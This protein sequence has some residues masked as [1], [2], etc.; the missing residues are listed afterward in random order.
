MSCFFLRVRK[1]PA[2]AAL[3]GALSVLSLSAS[4]QQVSFD[5]DIRP[6]MSD[7]C[8]RCHGPDVS[9]RMANMRLDI[10]EEALKP[11]V[12]GTPIVPG[13]PE[14]SEIIQRIFAKDGHVMPPPFAHKELTES[15]KEII[16]RWVEQ[17][18]KYEMHWSYVPITR[19]PVPLVNGAAKPNPIDAFVQARLAEERL[20]PSSEA[21]RRTLIRRV[22]LDLTGLAPTPEQTAAFVAGNSPDSYEKLVDR[23]LASPGY[24]EKQAV[25]WLDAVR[26]ADSAGFHSDG[27]RPAW[28]YRD[29]VL[30]SF[31]DNKPF[32][33]FTREQLAGDLMPNATVEDKVASAYNRMGRTSAEGGLQPKEYLAKY[34]AERVRALSTNW[35]GTTMGCSECHNHKFDP[36][37]TKDFYSMKAFFADIKEDGLIPDTGS[38]AFAPTMPVYKP[39]QK[40]RIDALQ[41]RIQSA[42][43]DLNRKAD[44]LAQD[45][46][47]WEKDL[48]ARAAAGDLTWT[49]P[50]PISVSATK[51][52][53]SVQ[54][55]AA[56]KDDHSHPLVAT[57]G[58]PGLVIVSGPNPDN[59][60]YSVTVRPGAGMWTSLG[61]EI[62]T[63]P[64]LAG[65]DISRGSDRFVISEVDA[66][67][68]ANGHRPGKRADFVFAYSTVTP[69]KGFPAAAVLDG[70]PNTGFGII[71]STKPP[72]LILRFAQ[73]LRTSAAATLTLQIHQ[74]SGYRQA[75]IGRF[76]IGLSKGTY[77][78]AN[79]P[80]P[81]TD[82]DKTDEQKA[83]K[84]PE[85][86]KNL[87][88]AAKDDAANPPKDN[89]DNDDSSD[90]DSARTAGLPRKLVRAFEKPEAKRSKEQLAL[91]RDYFEYSSPQ[92]FP[93]RLEIAKQEMDL[94]FLEG[95]VAEVMITETAPPRE[96]RILPRGNWMDDSGPVVQ[97]SI[98]EFLGHLNTGNRRA[99]R[100]DL[101]NWLVSPENPLTARVYMNR[102]WSEFFGAGASK[103][104]ED[105]G[106]QGDWPSH[107][108]LLNWL[109]AEFMNPQYDAAATHPWDIRHM[110]R[111][112]V[113]SETYRQSSLSSREL[114]ERDP[115]NRLLARQNRFRVDAESVHD[116][117]L[118]VSGLLVN[119]FGGPSVEPYQP[120]GYLA[121]LNFPKRSWSASHGDDLYRRGIYTFWQRTFL[122][123]TIM[124]FDA[125]T[126]EECAV[127][128]TISNTPL[129]ALDLL[130]DPTFVEAARVFG[131][132]IL[133][134]GGKDLQTQIRWAFREA[135]TRYPDNDE[136]QILL[137]L[138]AKSVAHF[139]AD[140]SQAAAYI[141]TGDS[142]VPQNISR[143]ELA[144]M[145]NVA[146]AILNLHEVIT[147]D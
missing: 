44:S 59:E 2:T 21:D 65:A 141:Q 125:P 109:A 39:G 31:R 35:L 107:L 8:F 14:H 133:Q 99:T 146:R 93:A 132:H 6:I 60:T 53:I 38:D 80:K 34:G 116:L 48:L 23:L 16:R 51:A 118:Q 114:D 43:D 127:F 129:Q 145:S 33:V 97:P 64:S 121:A 15:Q 47:A 3:V 100:L 94:S 79:N 28:P 87:A 136:L 45:R 85:V 75:T 55:E 66:T 102:L 57:T 106:S 88:S 134:H 82:A 4:G 113:L 78:W 139:K 30:A 9:S 74:D 37:L 18:A 72:L 117:M 12:H 27:T 131:A 91:V 19:P 142:A 96:T 130:N 143:V 1:V 101:A 40:E 137:D 36:V 124:N 126:R 10:R 54:T 98:P 108:Q 90:A 69:A 105:L 104:V 123:P 42:K 58:G 89:E 111:I 61:I 41:Q 147:R 32:D 52:K 122:H 49:F 11:K 56:E 68:S 26:Y 110:V 67:Y 25:R 77:S 13:D 120:D 20:K 115:E 17:G 144:A 140:G 50:I 84:P 95:A 71:G 112:I 62:D 92:L 24:A 76:R 22:T 46:Q 86:D 83:P 81:K 128:R 29:Y 7:T 119:K 70:N 135:T 103:T 5:R 63:D 73:P 138:H